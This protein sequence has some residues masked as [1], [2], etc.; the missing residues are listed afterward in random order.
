ML[1]AYDTEH[2]R[3]L[4]HDSQS[5]MT[6][7]LRHD[8]H[9]VPRPADGAITCNLHHHCRLCH[10]AILR[11]VAIPQIVVPTCCLQEHPKH[12]TSTCWCSTY[13]LCLSCSPYMF[14]TTLGLKR[15]YDAVLLH[16]TYRS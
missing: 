10:V 11:H 2:S 12:V 9:S 8:L 7:K 16:L 3:K 4:R 15:H 5:A 1:L 6:R 14:H 13:S